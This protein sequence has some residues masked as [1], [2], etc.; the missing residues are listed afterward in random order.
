MVEVIINAFGNP[1]AATAIE[2]DIGKLMMRHT[3]PSGA[4]FRFNTPKGGTTFGIKP[5]RAARIARVCDSMGNGWMKTSDVASLVGITVSLAGADLRELA[6]QGK[7]EKE[8]R[9]VYGGIYAHWR[10]VEG[11]T[12]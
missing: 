12:K 9:R 4:K 6:R 10:R 2:R 11:S 8:M 3:N 1:K 7:V 5:K